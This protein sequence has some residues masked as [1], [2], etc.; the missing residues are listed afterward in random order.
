MTWD[1]RTRA[2]AWFLVATLGGC[3]GGSGSG[4]S[5]TAGPPPIA[6][7]ASS[8]ATVPTN[9]SVTLTWS[10]T[11]ATSCTASGAWTGGVVTSGTKILVVSQTSTY[12]LSCS[13]AGGSASA[14]TVVTATPMVLAVTVQYQRPGA[15]VVNTAGTYYVPDWAHP[16]VAPVPYIY[17]EVDDPTGQP[18]QTTYANA[19]G[20]ASFTGLDPRVQYTPQIRSQIKNPSLG[21]DFEVLNNTAPIDPT[22]GTFRG[23]YAS[24]STSFSAYTPTN[25]VQQAVTVT[26]PDG[27]DASMGKLVD[28]DRIAAPYELLAFASFEAVTVSA[29]AGGGSWR[30]LTILWSVAN[31]GG[32]A[33]PPNNYDQ[34]TVT[35]SGG[36]YAS[37][38][39]SIGSGGTDS[40]TTLSED[41]IFLSGDQ[42]TEAM[43]IYPAV[44]THEMGHFAQSLFST[45][46]SPGG[47]H[48]YQDYEDFTL[49]WIEGSASGISAL[50][51][52]T[53]TQDRLDY[54]SG[55]IIVG[56]Y[57]I[58]DNTLSGNPQSWPVGWYQE[59]TTTAMMWAAYDPKG[60]MRLSAAATLAP[61]FSSAW[62]QGPYLNSIWA[63]DYLLKQANASIAAAVDTWSAAHNI[64][65][66]GNDV[67]GSTENHVGDTTA[68]ESLPPY[69]TINIGQTV[70]VCSA[71]TPLDYNKES[72]SRYLFLQGDGGAH[73]LSAQG[74]AG[75]V[76][77]LSGN[78]FTA[79]STSTTQS[80][81]VPIGGVVTVIG[82][83]SVSYSEFSSDTAACSEPAAPPPEQCWSVTWQ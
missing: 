29:A 11:N 83:C 25:V 58:S 75:T 82:D 14:S 23:R 80:G 31:K 63:Y 36:F 8:V 9:G 61:M 51:M 22:K 74:P 47:D 42:T 12:T 13:G 65:S 1:F 16:I 59:T 73:T 45:E 79:G 81:T 35:G 52:N 57:D 19:Q 72:N 34:G 28:A 50:V 60:T 55:E 17:V 40:G 44:M 20:V 6:T 43:D 54:V 68:Q 53:P 30:P 21:V 26:A 46:Q 32:L 64:V 66:A 33:A 3:G 10:S 69:T 27:W 78:M 15:P 7:L 76:P 38:H 41:Y 39:G 4:S 2:L 49:A 77:L 18:V 71:G 70:Q 56:I 62:Q 48:S 37:G 24:Y 5:S 67:W